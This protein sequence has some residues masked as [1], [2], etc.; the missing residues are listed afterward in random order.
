MSLIWFILGFAVGAVLGA[1]HQAITLFLYERYKA[2][3]RKK[4]EDLNNK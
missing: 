4:V 2:V 1:K 3:F